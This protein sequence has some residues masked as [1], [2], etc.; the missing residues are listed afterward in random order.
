MNQFEGFFK[1]LSK[2]LTLYQI[3][4]LIVDQ[5]TSKIILKEEIYLIQINCF[6]RAK[7]NKFN[8]LSNE[9]QE[10]KLEIEKKI[11]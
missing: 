10:I 2:K 5:L 8:L 11:L 1:F 9:K 7:C 3:E 4:E 6:G